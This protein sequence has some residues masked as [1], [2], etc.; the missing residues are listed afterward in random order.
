MTALLIAN[1]LTQLFNKTLSAGIF[2]STWKTAIVTAIYKRKGSSSDPSNYRPISLLSCVSKI[3]EKLVFAKIYTHI[4]DHS[5]LTEKQSGYRPGHSTQIQLVYLTHQIYS[6][7]DKHL[8]FTAVYLD[9]SKYFDTIWHDALLLKCEIQC[10]ITGSLLLWLKS[11]LSDRTQ[12][13]RVGS[14]F[15]EPQKIHA[16]CPQGSVLGPLLALIYLSDLSDKTDNDALFYADDTSL[17][18]SHP[19][20]SQEHRLSLQRDLDIIQHFGTDWAISFSAP[21]TIQQT[22]STKHDG[23]APDLK[24]ADQHIPVVSSHKHLGLTLSTD[25]RF[26]D[27]VNTI[28]RTVNMHLSPI[29]SVAKLLPRH[30]LNDIFITYIRPHFD[31]CDMIYD[32]NITIADATRLQTLQN[33]IAR[34]VTGT[35]PRTSTER[36]IDDLGWERLKTRRTAHK[37]TLFHR[38]RY[39]NPPLPNYITSTMSEMRQ[40]STGLTLRNATTLSSQ[41]HRLTSFK[42]SFIPATTHLWNQLPESVRQTQSRPIFCKLIWDHLGKTKP[43]LFY[44]SGTKHGNIIHTRLRV[45]LSSLNSHMYTTFRSTPSPACSCGYHTEDVKHFI[46]SCP[47]HAQPRHQLLTLTR[48]LIPTFDSLSRQEKVNTFLHGSNVHTTF[49]PKLAYIFQSFLSQTHRFTNHT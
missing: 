45:G 28:I 24:F 26:H 44:S 30:I 20:D 48:T 22:F 46:L 3:L 14:S 29:Y 37:L 16:G 36:L 41:K 10:G 5:I 15:S 1:P 47:N 42:N 4:T 19:H 18:S 17:Y 2:P 40:H 6:A 12:V 39:N 35:L 31:Y 23:L 43:P 8:D 7:L 9:I 27:H 32:G 38:I 25:L 13:V 49:H 11:Y 34:L 33:R 21:K